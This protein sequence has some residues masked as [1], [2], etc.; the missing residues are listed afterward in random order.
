MIPAN[1]CQGNTP[2]VADNLSNELHGM[3]LSK[4]LLA[5]LMLSKVMAMWISGLDMMTMM[6]VLA[7]KV[8]MKAKKCKFCTFIP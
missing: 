1:A 3:S 6:Y 7:M 5:F 2:I 4:C 8:S